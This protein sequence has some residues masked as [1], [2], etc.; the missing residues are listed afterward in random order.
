M[1]LEDGGLSRG[2]GPGGFHSLCSV[3]GTFNYFMY[4]R[5]VLISYLYMF[6]GIKMGCILKDQ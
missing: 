4:T 6:K 3:W 2:G 5:G 1:L